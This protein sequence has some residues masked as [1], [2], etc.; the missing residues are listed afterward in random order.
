MR[1]FLF[2]IYLFILYPA[3]SQAVVEVVEFDDAAQ[4]AQYQALIAELRCVVCQNQNI[5]DSDA[6]LAQDLRE[7]AADMIRAGQSD[8]EIKEFMVKRYS[9]F[10]L[11]RPAFS[12][13]TSLLWLAPLIVLLLTL[14]AVIRFVQKREAVIHEQT[15]DTAID[16]T[17]RRLIK[18]LLES[19]D[20]LSKDERAL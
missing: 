14:F 20:E 2:L 5:A 3:A 12:V 19:S 1:K 17:Q 4:Q 9:E 8:H 7:I 11:Y 13:A 10:V 15:N 18:Q 6:P 16:D